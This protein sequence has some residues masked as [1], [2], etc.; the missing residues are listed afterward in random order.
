MRERSWE[1]DYI[2]CNTIQDYG[3]H[4]NSCS[5]YVNST[6]LVISTAAYF[7]NGMAT[8]EDKY[9][10]NFGRSDYVRNHRW[11]HEYSKKTIDQKS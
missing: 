1:G 8:L 4:I 6:L 2:Y 3:G 5:H 11:V 10:T 7:D 9:G